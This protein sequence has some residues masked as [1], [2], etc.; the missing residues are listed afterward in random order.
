MNEVLKPC[1]FCG[2]KAKLDCEVY[3]SSDDDYNVEVWISCIE[4]YVTSALWTAEDKEDHEKYN[5]LA[6]Q[7]W[8]KRVAD[9]D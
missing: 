7:E 4:C 6:I 2:G 3:D 8:N 9:A 5:R 1:P